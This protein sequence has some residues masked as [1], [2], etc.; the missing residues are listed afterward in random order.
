VAVAE[1]LAFRDSLL[2]PL[3]LQEVMKTIKQAIKKIF[4]AGIPIFLNYN[5]GIKKEG[6]RILVYQFS[7]RVVHS[8]LALQV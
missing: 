3:I 8:P 4:V 2:V 1:S 6:E 5:I 7:A